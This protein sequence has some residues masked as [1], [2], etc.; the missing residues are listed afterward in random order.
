MNNSYS[1]REMVHM[2][3]Q[4]QMTEM[5]AR[6]IRSFVHNDFNVNIW[7]F[8][9]IKIEGCTSRD[10]GEILSKKSLI[11]IVKFTLMKS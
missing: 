2:F 5:R 3:W 1:N 8:N 7:S 4:G 11:C 9:N 10:A 6:C